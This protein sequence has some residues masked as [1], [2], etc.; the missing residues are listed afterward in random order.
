M[1]NVQ[2]FAELAPINLKEI[3]KI[4]GQPIYSNKR[5]QQ[6]IKDWLQ[7][8]PNTKKISAKISEGMDSGRILMGY[9]NTNKIPGMPACHNGPVRR[10]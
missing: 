9:E 6:F 2:E 8:S 1:E 4:S 7:R 10:C 5:I 3:G